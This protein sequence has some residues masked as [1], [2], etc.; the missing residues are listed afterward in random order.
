MS[1][2]PPLPDTRTEMLLPPS[3]NPLKRLYNW[4]LH[5]AATPFGVWALFVLAF[6]E[7]SFFPI[8]PD[9]LLVALCMGL[10]SRWVW[11]ALVCS[12]GSIAGGLAGYGIGYFFRDT[13]GQILLEWIGILVVHGGADMASSFHE[14][15]ANIATL[16]D[17]RPRFAEMVAQL[18]AVGD[19]LSIQPAV[20]EL[21]A[22]DKALW[23]RATALGWFN[24]PREIPGMG[25]VVLGPWAVGIAGF[26]PIPY[27]V[28][29]IS[30]GM[31]EMNVLSFAVASALSRS[32]RFFIVSAVIGLT[33]RIFGDRLRVF[34]DRW[35]NLLCTALV[36]L[37]VAGFVVLKYLK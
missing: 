26:T 5:W 17:E 24:C 28:F 36:V 21:T 12:I 22:G 7:S 31:F 27:K 4:V 34:I 29:T 18:R 14:L 2:T 19:T 3:R 37:G 8:P 10:P 23:L 35:F 6:A 13:L 11:F 15:A 25:Q 20:Y 1:E 32:A 30:S 33:Y 16:A 9:V